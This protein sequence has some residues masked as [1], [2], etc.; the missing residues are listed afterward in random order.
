M[1]DQLGL[2]GSNDEIRRC[3]KCRQVKLLSD[4]SKSKAGT[5]RRGYKSWCKACANSDLKKW[6]DA[7]P[8]H[9]RQYAKRYWESNPEYR[10]RCRA[11][12]R[13]KY[14]ENPLKARDDRLRYKYGIGLDEYRDMEARQGGVC[15]IC[16]LK[17]KTGR[18]LAVD[19]NHATGEVRGLLCGK[20]NKGIGLF[21]ERPELFAAAV[22][23][24]LSFQ[25]VLKGANP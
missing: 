12:E 6:R 2:F 9:R 16:G 18:E 22:A 5:G 7:N 8:D 24:L 3:T 4:F 15:A 11:A 23:Y 19:H 21:D 25:D 10:E 1:S 13:A 17:C 14:H 20:C